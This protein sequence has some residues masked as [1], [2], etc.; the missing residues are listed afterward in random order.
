[1]S[2][3]RAQKIRSGT[4]TK[5]KTVGDM[6]DSSIQKQDF[7]MRELIVCGGGSD[8]IP[9]ISKW[10]AGIQINRIIGTESG[11]WYKIGEDIRFRRRKLRS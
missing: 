3:T 11:K 10:E 8:G 9:G 7:P 4:I 2:Q 5:A 1:M 6:T